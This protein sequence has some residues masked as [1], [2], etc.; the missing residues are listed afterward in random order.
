MD[1]KIEAV[2]AQSYL[3]PCVGLVIGLPV[4]MV[5][6]LAFGYL[7]AA[8]EI[9]ALLTLLALYLVTGLIHLDGLAD[10]FDGLMAPGSKSDKVRAMKDNNLG[11]AGLF[12]TIFVLLISSFAIEII[13]ADLASAAFGCN[14]VSFYTFASVFILAEVS[15]KLSMNT[16]MVLGKGFD[17]HEG[18]GARFIQ[19][20]SPRKY[21]TALLSAVLIAFLFTVSVPFRFLI[22][23]TGIVVACLVSFIAKRKLGVMT[24]D[25]MGASN[26]L[27]RS[28]TL[29]L[30]W[31]LL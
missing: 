16:C 15:A 1:I 24:G 29:L 19:S 21:L 10:F 20:S 13:G 18:L 7:H 9:A 31:A 25:I 8:P 17:G 6:F 11:T 5:A 28:T 12:A 4:A 30:L 27:A 22:V 23:L 2:T 26:E 14:F 3:F